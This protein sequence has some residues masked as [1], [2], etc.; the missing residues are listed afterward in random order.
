MQRTGDHVMTKTK[1]VPAIT[2][3]AQGDLFG[4]VHVHAEKIVEANKRLPEAENF[5]ELPTK[6]TAMQD[7]DTKK[8]ARIRL[9]ND[10]FRTTFTNGKVMMTC[11]VDALSPDIKLAV[12]LKVRAFSDFTDD[13]D[14][15]NEHDFGSFE[16]AGEK[17][18]WKIDYYDDK[19]EYGSEDPSDSFKTTRVLTIMLAEEY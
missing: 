13:N 17:F 10:A 16:V 11:G 5:A 6:D 4:A 15:Y 7:Q 18:F 1:N 3:P 9:L 12:M 19:M 2:E 14:P 8:T